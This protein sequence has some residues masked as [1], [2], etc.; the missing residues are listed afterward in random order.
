MNFPD[1]KIRRRVRELLQGTANLEFWETYENG[2]VINYL[3]E[4][5]NILR[6]IQA[7]TA[8]TD[9]TKTAPI[10]VTAPA[11][12]TKKDQALEE[13]IGKDTS[14]AA[15]ANNRQ[16]FNLQN[17]L[18]AVLNPRVNEQGQPLPSSMI[19]LCCRYRHC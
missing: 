5:N 15:T 17:P 12:T 19:G 4:A 10:A 3:I 7:S 1:W 2:E 16:E 9:S 13:L 11:D 8:K 6:E 18:F 14:T